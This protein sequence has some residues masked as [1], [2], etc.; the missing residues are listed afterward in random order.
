MIYAKTTDNQVFSFDNVRQLEAFKVAM[1]AIGDTA[2]ANA[3]RVPATDD[4]VKQRRS[5]FSVYR[6]GYDDKIKRQIAAIK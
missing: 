4:L 3:K 6:Y 5:G 2:G 1:R